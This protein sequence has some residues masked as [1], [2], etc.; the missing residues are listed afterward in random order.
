M[1]YVY[2]ILECVISIYI[3]IEVRTKITEE[4]DANLQE[5]RRPS[6]KEAKM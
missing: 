4:I 1:R 2:I 5:K 6:G 3:K